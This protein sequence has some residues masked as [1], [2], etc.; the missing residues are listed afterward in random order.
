MGKEKVLLMPYGFVDI[1]IC[2]SGEI[3]RNID[4]TS[5]FCWVKKII[6]WVKATI[7]DIID[8]NVYPPW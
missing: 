6:Y 3:P 1:V 4:K 8:S 7:K 5:M 2:N